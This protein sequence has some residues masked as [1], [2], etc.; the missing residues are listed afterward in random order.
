MTINGPSWLKNLTRVDNAGSD[1]Y[2]ASKYNHVLARVTSAISDENPSPWK[3]DEINRDHATISSTMITGD[4]KQHTTMTAYANGDMEETVR[5]EPASEMDKGKGFT[6][7]HSY[8]HKFPSDGGIV[9]FWTKRTVTHTTSMDEPAQEQAVHSASVADGN[10]HVDTY[11]LGQ[12]PRGEMDA[13]W[14]KV[15]TF[16]K[17]AQEAKNDLDSNHL[18]GT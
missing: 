17:S 15:V 14:Y 11:A 7:T 18:V 4:T 3:I 16:D 8:L 5:R 1:V 2:P 6:V 10:G 12:T 13:P 9:G